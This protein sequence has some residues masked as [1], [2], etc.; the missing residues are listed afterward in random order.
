M[1]RF[2]AVIV[3]GHKSTAMQC[4]LDQIFRAVGTCAGKL[5]ILS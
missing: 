2:P 3:L 5:R 1:L 4:P